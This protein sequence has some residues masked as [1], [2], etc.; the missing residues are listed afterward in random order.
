MCCSQTTG[1]LARI[2]IRVAMASPLADLNWA[3]SQVP[4]EYLLWGHC[5]L[6]ASWFP[7]LKDRFLLSYWVRLFAP[8]CASTVKDHNRWHLLGI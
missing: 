5:L 1:S 4:L 7:H 8:L 6:V 2:R 3:I